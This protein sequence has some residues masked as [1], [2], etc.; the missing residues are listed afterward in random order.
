MEL[1]Q[2]TAMLR[3]WLW[4]ILLGTILAAG[5]AY[6]VSSMQTP[7]YQASTTLLINQAPDFRTSDYTALLTSERLASTYAE[8][9]TQQPVLDETRDR[10]GMES[11]GQSLG[12][13]SV[14]PVRDTQLLT[15]SVEHPSPEWAAAVANMLVEVFAAQNLALQESRYSETKVSLQV[16]LE[17]LQEQIHSIEGAIE[18]LGDPVPSHRL[19]ELS[20]L[21]T[22]LSS[23]RQSYTSVLQS[24]EALRIAEAQSVSNVVPVE[25][26]SVPVAP[27]RPRIMTNTV[28]AAVVGAMVAVGL[29]FLIEYLDDTVKSPEELARVTDIPVIGMITDVGKSGE[30]LPYVAEYPRS[31]VAEA[32]RTLRS[33]IEFSG[34]NHPIRTLLITSPGPDEGKS[35]IAANLAVVMAQRGKKVI[36]M[37]SDLRR[38]RMHRIMGIPNRIGL[39]DLFVREPF[40]LH[41]VLQPWKTENLLYMASGGL[42]PNPA[43]LLGSERMKM[44]IE[45]VASE[46]SIVIID[47]P[48]LGIVTDA[49]VIAAQVDA[50]LLVIE[51]KRTPLGAVIHVVDQLQRAD[52][53]IIG[54]VMNGVPVRDAGYYNGYYRGYYHYSSYGGDGEDELAPRRKRRRPFRLFRAFSR[55][56]EQERER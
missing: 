53:H 40:D 35:T 18:D 3:R 30:G 23:Y 9:I 11:P 48:P 16:E 38:P 8:M 25:P 5:S 41:G 29:I 10:L 34:V 12:S 15:V 39:S 54:I 43:E 49:A 20:R 28:M 47:S 32:F 50:V 14:Q 56:R 26:A 42:P 46:S 33:N 7:I 4:L 27:I 22:D 45:K 52:A 13:I 36:L 21:Q 17:R 6:F 31:P 51:P 37:D 1:R 55:S 24:Y 2:Y 19:S 44:I